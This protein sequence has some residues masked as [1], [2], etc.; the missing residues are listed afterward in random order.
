[1]S[2][3]FVYFLFF[4]FAFLIFSCKKSKQTEIPETISVS[5]NEAVNLFK[6]NLYKNKIDSVFAKYD[7]NGSIAVFQDSV[8]LARKDVGF[9]DFNSKTEIS[10]QTI[11]AIG[12]VS[13]QFTAVLILQLT[14]SGKLKLDDKVSQYLSDFQ[15]KDYENITVQQLLNHTS[16]ISDSGNGLL[17]KSGSGFSYSNKGFYFLGKLIEKVSGKDLNENYAELFR[18]A[19][20]KNTYT[21]ENFTGNHFAGT[22]LGNPKKFQKVENMPKR[23]AEKSISISAGGI[24]S[25]VDDLHLWNQALYSG[26]LLNSE[27]LKQFENKS[28][29]RNHPIFGKMGYGFGIMMSTGKPDSFF[30][31]G[32]VK[33]SPSLNIYYPESKISIIILSNIADES[34]GKNTIFKPHR[35]MKDFADGIEIVKIDFE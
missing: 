35:E 17:F 24:L 15:N 33:G 11:F 29:D 32:Y 28:A 26:K 2:K 4:C 8:L 7:F 3:R 1:V 16:G 25:T 10:D 13:K 14:E 27:S 6:K 20:M 31:S 9:E 5:L 19:G 18:K 22:Y 30:H 21:A 23:L 12:S 34:A